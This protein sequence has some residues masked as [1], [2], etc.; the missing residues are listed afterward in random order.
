MG[1]VCKQVGRAGVGEGVGD[2]VRV[3]CLLDHQGSGETG[4]IGRVVRIVAIDR[5]VGIL[6]IVGIVAVVGIVGI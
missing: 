1:V 3:G 2:R 4:V 5:I 6:A